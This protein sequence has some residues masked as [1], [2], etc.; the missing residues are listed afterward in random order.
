MNVV[1]NY[2]KY[3]GEVK[4]LVDQEEN[5]DNLDDV[6]DENY[7]F[8]EE[9]QNTW[10]SESFKE[11]SD[12]QQNEDEMEDSN[13]GERRRLGKRQLK[14]GMTT[15]SQGIARAARTSGAR[16]SKQVRHVGPDIER[17]EKYVQKGL[18]CLTPKYQT[19]KLQ[20]FI[21]IVQNMFQLPWMK[22]ANVLLERKILHLM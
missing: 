12:Q 4:F 3:E 5:R 19:V 20:K 1:E 10:D 17:V 7:N 22:S 2:R 14:K 13:F 9:D 11:E 16:Y 15:V 8:D 6:E 18:K 21:P